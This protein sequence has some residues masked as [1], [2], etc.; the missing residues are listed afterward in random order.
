M[1]KLLLKTRLQ[2]YCHYIK[3]N[4]DRIT[5]VE[6]AAIFFI[7]L[8]LLLRSPADIGYRL[9][10]LFSSEFSSVWVRYFFISLPAFYLLAELLAW[11]TLRPAAEWHLLGTLPFSKRAIAFYF[12]ARHF[13]KTSFL[14]LSLVLL[15]FA[16]ADA[17][18]IRCFRFL[19]GLGLIFLLQL[20]SF[21]QA[22]SLRNP[23]QRHFIGKIRWLVF[24]IIVVAIL[25]FLPGIAQPILI[26]PLTSFHPSILLIWFLTLLM[27][28]AVLKH[29]LPYLPLA[30]ISNKSVMVKKVI[31]KKQ[32]GRFNRIISA[33]FFRDIILLR[34]Q[35]RSAFWLTISGVIFSAFVTLAMEEAFA[36]YIA[37]LSLQFVWSLLFFNAILFLFEQ[38]IIG[39]ELNKSLPMKAT[40][41]WW[42]RWLVVFSFISGQLVIPALI[43]PV[44]FPITISFLFFLLAGLAGVPAI[45]ATLF[46]NSG[47][48]L[49]PHIRL[50]GYLITISLLL[51]ILFWFF[52]PVGSL[53]ILA[54]II[55]WVHRSQ[56][57]FQ[58]LEL[59]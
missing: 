26:E 23:H 36:A 27:L 14:I 44:K 58:F 17:F 18:F 13:I 31:S 42:A 47:F 21:F 55:F 35:K 34:R 54:V 39:Y 1:F 48:G 12:L 7:F 3:N 10:W 38:D 15:F 29:F 43:I 25:L 22:F 51:I 28:T 49:F 30:K 52:M 59:T 6:L 2:Y 8:Y 20:V 19:A 41:L 5:A 50:S 53:I 37:L 32:S 11:F 46:C 16:G 57:R 33:L 45:M 40:S 24:D 56:K 4:F 9:N